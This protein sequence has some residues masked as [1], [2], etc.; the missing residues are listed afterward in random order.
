MPNAVILKVWSPDQQHQHH[1]AGGAEGHS[2]LRVTGLGVADPGEGRG[3]FVG[4]A[5]PEMCL[6]GWVGLREE[7]GKDISDGAEAGRCG[8]MRLI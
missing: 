1:L 6:E 7:P 8:S 5:T 2:N 3:C 4:E